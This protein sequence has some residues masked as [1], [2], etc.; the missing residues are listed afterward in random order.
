MPIDLGLGQCRGRK[1]CVSIRST[2]R[3]PSRSW[4][5]QE[6]RIRS[7]RRE[8]FDDGGQRQR[9]RLRSP[10]QND[11]AS[12]DGPG[13]P[14]PPLFDRKRL[15]RRVAV[16]DRC[17]GLTDA[18]RNEKPRLGG[19]SS[20]SSA[21]SGVGLA[22]CARTAPAARCPIPRRAGT[23]PAG[24]HELLGRFGRALP[25]AVELLAHRVDRLE[26]RAVLHRPGERCALALGHAAA[27]AESHRLSGARWE[28]ARIRRGRR[29][30][31]PRAR[32]RRCLQR[33][34]YVVATS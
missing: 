33:P 22:A 17:A 6:T 1:T 10:L 5:G 30:R 21:G 7:T 23:S 28:R 18:D 19:A 2:A 12:G 25:E 31:A 11:E 24:A 4:V 9:Q 16:S 3:E 32:R 29:A 26:R 20:S 14:I 8:Q 13:P 34:A 15:L 27:V